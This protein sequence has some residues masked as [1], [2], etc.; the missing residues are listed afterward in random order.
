MKIY[1]DEI[2]ELNID[3]GKGEFILIAGGIIGIILLILINI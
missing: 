1:R 2:G 3:I